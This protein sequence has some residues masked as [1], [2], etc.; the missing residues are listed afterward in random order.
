MEIFTIKFF[1]GITLGWFWFCYIH[2]GF[3]EVLEEVYSI[4]PIVA[5]IVSVFMV[6]IIS[7]GFSILLTNLGVK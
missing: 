4:N 3:L 1:L 5:E 6:F 7:I 2:K